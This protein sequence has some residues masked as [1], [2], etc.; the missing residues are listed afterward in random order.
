M[1]QHLFDCPVCQRPVTDYDNRN[2]RDAHIKPICNYCESAYSERSPAAGAFMDR[3]IAC[4]LS[5]L[6]NALAGKAMSIEWGGKY[7][8]A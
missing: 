4:R 1:M 7:G 8:K 3:R 2:G 5:A 6:S